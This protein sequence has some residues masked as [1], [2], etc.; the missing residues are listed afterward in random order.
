MKEGSVVSLSAASYSSSGNIGT[1]PISTTI[2]LSHV[3]SP[4]PS[5]T[6]TVMLNIGTK[7]LAGCSRNICPSDVTFRAVSAKPSGINSN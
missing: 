2:K 4:P 3:L 7:V 1:K 5:I 6:H